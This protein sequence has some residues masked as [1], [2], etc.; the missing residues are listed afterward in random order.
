MPE[1]QISVKKGPDYWRLLEKT[2]RLVESWPEWKTGG[3]RANPQQDKTA[4]PARV[5]EPSTDRFP[6]KK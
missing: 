1:E 5:A 3:Q 2:A 6:V 4:N